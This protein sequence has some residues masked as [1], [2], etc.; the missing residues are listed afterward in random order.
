MDPDPRA[1]PRHYKWGLIYD[2]P[3]DPRVVVRKRLPYLGWTLNFGH[4]RVWEVFGA[5]LAAA[6]APFLLVTVVTLPFLDP[7][8][9]ARLLIALQG[10]AAVASV[11]L[12][13]WLTRYFGRIG[14]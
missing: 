9:G 12:V 10:G 5:I 4:P 8:G 14:R 3:Q 2:D 1:D 6:L 11:V 13:L 7:P